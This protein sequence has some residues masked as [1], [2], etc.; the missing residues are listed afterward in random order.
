V[1]VLVQHMDNST[2]FACYLELITFSC[3]EN[4]SINCISNTPHSFLF[5]ITCYHIMATHSLHNPV[6]VIDHS[7]F[8]INLSDCNNCTVVTVLYYEIRKGRLMIY[9]LPVINWNYLIQLKIT[10]ALAISARWSSF[11]KRQPFKKVFRKRQTNYLAQ[12]ARYFRIDKICFS[13]NFVSK[14][15]RPT[16]RPFQLKL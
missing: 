8:S 12:A 14:E 6:F 15:M 1:K 5:F 9:Y 4:P 10:R 11:N 13:K 7:A 3:E 2:G 16:I